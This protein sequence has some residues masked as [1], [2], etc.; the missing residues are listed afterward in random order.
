MPRILVINGPNLNLLGTRE[1][2]IYGTKTL[3]DLETEVTAEAKML[4]LQV[5]FFQSNSESALVDY[6]QREAGSADGLIING[7]AFSHYSQALGDAISA[8]GIR[9]IEIHIS[10]VYA[11]EEFRH[12]SVIAPLAVGQIVGLGLD[13]YRLAL[14]WFAAHPKQ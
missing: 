9:T 10:N 4:G 6:I 2:A 1:P 7:G 5:S 8:T 13:G 14:Q 11:R 12:K 3:R